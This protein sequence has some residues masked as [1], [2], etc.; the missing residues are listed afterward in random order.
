MITR[1]P[2]F[3]GP[4][5]RSLFGW[6][7][8][9]EAG[10]R[11][12]LAVLI[13]PPLGHEYVNSHRS[14]RHLTDRIAEAG[15]PAMRFDY[16]GTGDSAGG[17]E[18]EGRLA[19]WRQS[20]RVGMQTL[21]DLSGCMRIVLAG[22]RF[23]ATL[24]A[25]AAGDIEVAGLVL[26]TP[27]VRGRAYMRELKA[28]QLT[29]GT[30]DSP[31][32]EP[33]GFLYTEE[34]QREIGAVN[35]EELTPKTAR[36]LLVAR[37]D[38]T[39]ET[40]LRD[41]WRAAGI[42]VEQ[43]AVPGYNE[44]YAP[45]HD[46]VVPS[47]AIAVTVRWVVAVAND[48]EAR[49]GSVNVRTEQ[50]VDR[51]RESIVRFGDGLFGILSEPE[52]PTGPA[53]LLNN[54]GSTHH[55][56]PNRL[57]VAMARALARTGFRVFRYDLPGLG[58]SVI[59]DPARE[60]DSYLPETTAIIAAAMDALQADSFVCMGLCSGAHA[61]FHAARDVARAAFVESVLINPLTFYYR[62]GMSLNQSP[63]VHHE[64][65]QRYLV[66]MRSM[67]GW[68]KL[69][70]GD[71][72]ISL[73]LRTLYSR[74]RDIVRG[75]LKALRRKNDQR[76]DLAADLRRIL[77][78]GRKMTFIFS[79]SDPGYDLLMINAGNVVKL[80]RKRG[81]VQLWRID[82]ANHTFEARSSRAVMIETLTRHLAGRYL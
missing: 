54:S 38:L 26:W 57:Y 8:A 9:P 65:W 73:I 4:G 48:G 79:R 3:F 32:L 36:V 52:Q 2:L 56:G 7:H 13:C 60:N 64:E 59:A 28:L 27:V 37:N 1:T 69:L 22:A 55:V 45:P 76:D 12:D 61:S 25:L 11:G 68:S 43:V 10:P 70:R 78:L 6:Y 5:Q 44:M 35:L 14:I 16:D 71:V 62:P 47:E 46:T 31:E 50:R 40:K 53:I 24:A 34:T 19:A 63:A 74:T 67:A 51:I 33:G 41:K 77:E 23:G 21:R 49:P 20:I 42:E 15:V 39:E 72:R 29:G 80:F 17:D 75:K 82:D 58:D 81:L 18:D 66:S 30:R